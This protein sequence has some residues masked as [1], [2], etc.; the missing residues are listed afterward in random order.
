[1]GLFDSFYSEDNK[2][3]LQIKCLHNCLSAFNVGRDMTEQL[4]EYN[5]P[6][7]L[8]FYDC[9][10]FAVIVNGKVI[11]VTENKDISILPLYDKYGSIIKE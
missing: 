8:T 5:F 10:K 3:E 2:L 6:L 1:M 11:T 7:T 9:G 4:S